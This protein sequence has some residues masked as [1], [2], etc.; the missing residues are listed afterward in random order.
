MRALN[1][2][3]AGKDCHDTQ[4]THAGRPTQHDVLGWGHVIGG[5][6]I[7]GLLGGPPGAIIGADVGVV[8]D[9]CDYVRSMPCNN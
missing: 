3:E 2:F 9:W 8:L 4:A 6:L 5:G 7:G 1:G